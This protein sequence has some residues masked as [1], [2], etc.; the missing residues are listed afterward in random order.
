MF[1]TILNKFFITIGGAEMLLGLLG[2]GL[3]F[4]LVMSLIDNIIDL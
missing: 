1:D 3:V 2:T 4:V